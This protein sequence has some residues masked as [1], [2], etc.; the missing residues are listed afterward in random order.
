MLSGVPPRTVPASAETHPTLRMLTDEL[1]MQEERLAQRRADTV[2]RREEER[3]E[4][5]DDGH[6]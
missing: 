2:R 5:V 1:R 6:S 4:C 3:G